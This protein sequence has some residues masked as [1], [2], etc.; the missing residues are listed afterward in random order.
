M[1]TWGGCFEKYKSPSVEPET[2]HGPTA[3]IEV[4][5]RSCMRLGTP[6]THG[7]DLNPWCL[8][9][10]PCNAAEEEKKK[11][12]FTFQ[13]QNAN[14]HCT[15]SCFFHGFLFRFQS[16]RYTEHNLVY[17]WTTNMQKKVLAIHGDSLVSMHNT[18]CS[19]FRKNQCLPNEAESDT[20][21]HLEHWKLRSESP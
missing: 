8:T 21:D 5:V 3:A 13:E 9:A 11:R 12:F 15:L 4:T 17:P 20:E 19:P 10:S 1:T 7:P 2:S 6:V 18:S 16:R 14:H